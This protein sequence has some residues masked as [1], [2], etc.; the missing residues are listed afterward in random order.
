V[1]KDLEIAGNVVT[2]YGGEVLEVKVSAGA[3]VAAGDPILSIQ[4]NVQ[5]LDV[6]LYLPAAQPEGS[7]H[8]VELADTD[9]KTKAFL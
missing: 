6:L 4:P 5:D 8:A 7:S 1:E 9:G 3:S 2:P